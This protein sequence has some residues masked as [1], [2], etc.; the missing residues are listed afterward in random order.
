MLTTAKSTWID[1]LIRRNDK[2][3]TLTSNIVTILF[4][5][6]FVLIASARAISDGLCC[7]DDAYFASIAKNFAKGM[8]YGTSFH[9]DGIKLFDPEIGTG[10]TVILPA[11][12]SIF[13]FGNN[14][15][16]PG[17]TSV[18]I[19]SILFIAIYRLL[20]RS[21]NPK[22]VNASAALFL[23]LVYLVFPFHY[24]HW[25][26]LLGEVP[27]ALFLILGILIWVINTQRQSN[28]AFSCICL[29]L[30]I[31]AKILSFLTVGA[32]FAVFIIHEIAV[33]RRPL[34][35]VIKQVSIASIFL[36]IPI[37]AFELAKLLTLGFDGYLNNFVA[38]LQ[39]ILNYSISVEKNS[40]WAQ[41]ISR[42][43]QIHFRFGFTALSMC[44]A[45]LIA[46]ITLFSASDRRLRI[47]GIT[48]GF[49]ILLNLI[50]YIFISVGWPRHL[51]IAITL[52]LI[53]VAMSAFALSSVKVRVIYLILLMIFFG[54]NFSRLKFPLRA[55]DNG[56]FKESQRLNN[57]K[58]MTTFLDSHRG[59]Y[60]IYGQWWATYIDYEYLSS[61]TSVVKRLIT[62]R[63]PSRQREA[64]LVV[65]NNKWANLKDK[66][67]WDIIEDCGEP[68]LDLPPYKVFTCN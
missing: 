35:E 39:F 38:Y 63:Q 24:E 44:G 53:L 28:I 6:T 49:A 47:A 59:E 36:A 22:R 14:A 51:I 68:T 21:F 27:A 34:V 60:N 10:P 42:N 48:L 45:T 62:N 23:L 9:S 20:I 41:A 32:F 25:F 67:F 2:F 31:L 46:I 7:A 18:V 11:S 5:T 19:W 58:T 12:L 8:G 57:L 26:T 40:I 54:E 4:F 66:K 52:F 3:I 30:A 55:M 13:L 43:S 65:L 37:L 56:W 1:Q 16:V 33:V 50:W 29:S 64:F 17:L 15:A 61:G